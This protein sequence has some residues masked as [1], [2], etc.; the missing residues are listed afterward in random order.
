[1]TTY[2]EAL[3]EKYR[4]VVRIAELQVKSARDLLLINEQYLREMEEKLEESAL[5]LREAQ[6]A[7]AI[8][9]GGE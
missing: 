2:A 3:V 9:K 5:L 4:A 1:M 8:K 7:Q 6:A